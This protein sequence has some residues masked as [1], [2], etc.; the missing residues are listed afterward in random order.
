MRQDLDGI[1]R[2]ADR[3]RKGSRVL[4]NPSGTANRLIN[5]LPG[6]A[7]AG[8]VG[9][10]SMPVV[11]LALSTPALANASARLMTNPKFVRWVGQSTRIP[12]QRLP[13]H[14]ARLA[15]TLED[16]PDALE[17]ANQFI[18]F[19]TAGPQSTQASQVTQ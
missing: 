2:A 4:F 16:D 5:V 9:V 7:A 15:N 3:I 19:L 12:A 14:I 11:L 18:D 1:A 6:A 17:A 10:G 8:G 13:G